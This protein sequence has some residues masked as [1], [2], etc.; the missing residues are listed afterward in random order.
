VQT[1]APFARS[2]SDGRS[3]PGALLPMTRRLPPTDPG[4]RRRQDR[5]IRA[6]LPSPSYPFPRMRPFTSFVPLA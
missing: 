5:A 3:P 1:D 6:P 2:F 4:C